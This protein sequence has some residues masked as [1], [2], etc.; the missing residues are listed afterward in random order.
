MMDH[1]TYCIFRCLSGSKAYGTSTPESDTDERGVYIAPPASILSVASQPEQYTDNTNDVCIYEL[2]KFLALAAN[3][4]PNVVELLFIENNISVQDEAW[5]EIR[6]HRHLFLSKQAHNTFSCY[7]LSQLER[8]KGHYKWI[9]NPQPKEHPKMGDYCKLI[10]TTGE[11]VTSPDEIRKMSEGHTLIS[12]FADNH[13]IFA[14]KGNLHGF[15]ALDELQLKVRNLDQPD[16][17]C[18]EYKGL[19]IVNKDAFKR[20]FRK[21]KQY[22]EWKKTR[23]VHRA[24]LEEKF[25]YDTKHALHLVRLVRMAKEILS[26]GELLVHRPDASEL[27]EI[28]NGKWTYSELMKYTEEMKHEM[29]KALQNSTLPDKVDLKEINQLY[30]RVTMNYWHRQELI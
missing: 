26:S 20:D 10:T 27:L 24:K 1:E 23:N 3:V 19:L 17:S 18:G 7:A 25:S 29:E 8:M 13:R 9:Q 22:W 11:I 6:K 30:L 4:N 16:D 2:R 28:K 5:K 15:F 21:W 12:G 14:A